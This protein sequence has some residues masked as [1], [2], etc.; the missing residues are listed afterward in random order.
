MSRSKCDDASQRDSATVESTARQEILVDVRAHSADNSEYTVC[1]N[2]PSEGWRRLATHTRSG[3]RAGTLTVFAQQ[4]GDTGAAAASAIED[5]SACCEGLSLGSACVPQGAAVAFYVMTLALVVGVGIMVMRS[6]AQLS[7]LDANK[8]SG[9]SASTYEDF[10]MEEQ[11]TLGASQL[12]ASLITNEIS[13]LGGSMLR[14]APSG[15]GAVS[16]MLDVRL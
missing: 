6:K 9:D 2:H 14:S 12:N 16:S 15:S 1:W 3:D 5:D 7:R 8:A 13:S 11:S 4:N 10:D